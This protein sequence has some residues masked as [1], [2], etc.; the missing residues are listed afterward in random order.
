M[1]HV[2]HHLL[3]IVDLM[4][5]ADEA[6]AKH[7]MC[8]DENK[9]IDLC[10]LI[11]RVCAVLDQIT[12]NRPVQKSVALSLLSDVQNLPSTCVFPLHRSRRWE[13]QWCWRC[14]D[15]LISLDGV[16]RTLILDYVTASYFLFCVTKTWCDKWQICQGKI[17]V[18][19]INIPGEVSFAILR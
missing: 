12:T 2:L 4:C 3:L 13:S 11:I 10:W 1:L 15:S 7:C 8:L 14:S 5:L 19:L 17:N 18:T 6:V 16:W 9:R